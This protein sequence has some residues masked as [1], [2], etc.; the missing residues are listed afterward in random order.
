MIVRKRMCK[1]MHEGIKYFCQHEFCYYI[2]R[3]VKNKKY[4][5]NNNYKQVICLEEGEKNI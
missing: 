1:G 3:L 5:Y 4:Y 2:N